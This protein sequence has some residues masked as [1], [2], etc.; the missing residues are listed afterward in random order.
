MS[1]PSK[2][3]AKWIKGREHQAALKGPAGE[4]LRHRAQQEH[5]DVLT[6]KADEASSKRIGSEMTEAP[7]RTTIKASE[8]RPGLNLTGQPTV[9]AEL[10]RLADGTPQLW[11]SPLRASLLT[12]G[13]IE[14]VYRPC[15]RCAGDRIAA[16]GLARID[17]KRE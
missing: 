17:A 16:K 5:L 3:P 9:E 8:V 13:L 2:D 7:R 6:A 15:G 10:R 11:F 4:L 14:T 1:S 12:E